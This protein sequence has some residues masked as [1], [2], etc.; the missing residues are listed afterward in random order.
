MLWTLTLGAV[1]LH[2]M[3]KMREEQGRKQH[4]G[5]ISQTAGICWQ[6]NLLERDRLDER[7]GYYIWE[8]EAHKF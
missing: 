7:V 1:V 4:Q 3:T 2:C 8:I 5:N 6:I